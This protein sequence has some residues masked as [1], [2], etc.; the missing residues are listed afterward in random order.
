MSAVA[1]RVRTTVEGRVVAAKAYRRPWMRFD[2]ELS[3]GTG[4]LILRFLG[5]REI[6]GMK[7]DARV[8][9]HGTPGREGDELIMRN[10]LYCFTDGKAQSV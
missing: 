4:T 1:P 8:M 10:P 5:R 7:V 2:V 3:D 9:A 6:L